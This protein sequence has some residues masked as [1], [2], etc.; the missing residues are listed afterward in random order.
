MGRGIGIA[1]LTGK[2]VDEVRFQEDFTSG[3]DNHQIRFWLNVANRRQVDGEWTWEP[4]VILVTARGKWVK[5]YEKLKAGDRVHIDGGLEMQRWTDPSDLDDKGEARKKSLLFVRATTIQKGGPDNYNRVIFLGRAA[6]DAEIKYFSGGGC[7]CNLLLAY[8]VWNA[9]KEEEEGVFVNVDIFG[10]KRAESASEHIKKGALIKIDRGM[11]QTD[12]WENE[13]TGRKE[14]KTYIKAFDW[15]F[16]GS[17]SGSG[18][19]SDD[20]GGWGFGPPDDE[21]GYGS[22]DDYDARNDPRDRPKGIGH[23]NAEP[24]DDYASF[25]PPPP[26]AQPQQNRRPQPADLDDDIPF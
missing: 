12:V 17:K 24:P 6:K 11:L 13:R 23:A 26:T 7:K 5:R 18:S 4:N 10:E 2:V 20:D 1:I 25:D 15:G 19:A 9:R 14:R 3:S 16:E 8:N 22:G 21:D